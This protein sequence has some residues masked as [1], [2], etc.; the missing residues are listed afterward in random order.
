MVTSD[1]LTKKGYYGASRRHP[2]VEVPSQEIF[3]KAV[4]ES[5]RKA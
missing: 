3:K 5:E 1:R 2:S 4:P